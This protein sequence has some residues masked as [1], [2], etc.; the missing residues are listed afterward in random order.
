MTSVI[1]IAGP[2][3]S[4]K[5]RL[6]LELAADERGVIVNADS[7]QVYR[8]LRVLTARPTEADEAAA[9]HRLYGHVPAATRYS[10]GAWLAD[11]ALILEEA[12][13]GGRPAIVVGGTGLYFKALREGLAA[14]PAVPAKVREEVAAEAEGVETPALHARLAALDPE[15][16]GLIR[17]SDRSRIVRALEVFAV[18][19]M[20]IAVWQKTGAAKPL[21]DA[22][23]ARR[24]VLS[25]DR[26]ELHRRIATRAEAMVAGGALDE[27]R[28][29]AAL[30]LDPAMP[31]MK[32]I[33]VRELRD[34]LAGK[35]SRTE[36]VAAIATETRRYARRQ[37]TW[38]R[39]QMADWPV[40][41]A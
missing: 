32:A 10:V 22:A 36:T 20:P 25:P 34:H 4:G 17:P 1:L 41:P 11:V 7:M 26:A 29:L 23:Q 30:D 2:T 13:R 39:N 37:L 9:P 14:M 12:R 35:T 28:A 24:L 31:A 8:E 21:V 19:G 40:A 16:A 15:S 33:G 38:F 27:V 6:A 3:A 5:S 18:T